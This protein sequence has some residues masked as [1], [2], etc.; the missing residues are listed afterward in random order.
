MKVK[1]VVLAGGRLPE[2]KT[3]L[4]SGADAYARG[5]TII[6]AGGVRK[7][8]LG[9]AVE[10]AKTHELQIRP[11]S[12]HSMNGIVVV[13]GTVDADYREE[14]HAICHNINDYDVTV[15]GDSRIAQ[16]V[17]VPVDRATFESSLKLSPTSRKGGFG[18]TGL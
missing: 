10:F 1:T 18:S 6:P 16:L 5:D 11:R 7:V 2:Y 12:G 9:V 17:L 8:P 4:A 13:L 3:A 14:I 15:T